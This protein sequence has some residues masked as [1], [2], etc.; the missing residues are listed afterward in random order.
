MKA[1]RGE[2]SA[3]ERFEVSKGWFM[4]LKERSHL[5]NTKAEAPSADVEAE[6]RFT[7]D[8]PKIINEGGSALFSK[9]PNWT[10]TARKETSKP[11][12]KASQD[13]LT[14]SLVASA[15]NDFNLKPMLVCLE[16]SGIMLN[17]FCL[18]F[19]NGSRLPR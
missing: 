6:A 16:R 3:E 14:L 7:E 11:D 15:A 5:Q 19:T 2:E 12:F 1:E 10:F 17:L 9:M 4:R 8:L 13:T 18:C